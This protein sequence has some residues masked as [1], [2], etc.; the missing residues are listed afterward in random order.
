MRYH[1]LDDGVAGG[2][3]GGNESGPS[4]QDARVREGKVDKA[5]LPVEVAEKYMPLMERLSKMYAELQ[6]HREPLCYLR[7]ALSGLKR[8]YEK[9]GLE[10]PDFYN[11]AAECIKQSILEQIS[12]EKPKGRSELLS[13][14]MMEE[15]VTEE[16]PSLKMPL[17][18]REKRQIVSFVKKEIASPKSCLEEIERNVVKRFFLDPDRPSFEIIAEELDILPSHVEGIYESALTKLRK[19][20]G[21]VIELS[22]RATEARWLSFPAPN[23]KNTWKTILKETLR[24][25][26]FLDEQGKIKDYETFLNINSAFFASRKELGSVYRAYRKAIEKQYI[27]IPLSSKNYHFILYNLGFVRKG[28][29]FRYLARISDSELQYKERVRDELEKAGVLN[30]KGQIR[31]LDILLSINYK[32]FTTKR[33]KKSISSFYESY[34]KATRRGAITLPKGAAVHHFILKHLGF[35]SDR[36]WKKYLEHR[37]TKGPFPS[38]KQRVTWEFVLREALDEA[39]KLNAEGKIKDLE[40]LRGID[41]YFFDKRRGRDSPSAMY[42]AYQVAIVKGR[43]KIPADAL[44]QHLILWDLDFINDELWDSYLRREDDKKEEH[45]KLLTEVLR[46]TS[47]LNASGKIKDYDTLMSITSDFFYGRTGK[48]GIMT[49]YRAYRDEIKRGNIVLPQGVTIQHFLLRDLGFVS[50]KLWK[51]YLAPFYIPPKQRRVWRSNLRKALKAAD[52]LNQKGEIKDFN[53]LLSV[54]VMFF[55]VTRGND[56]P[57]SIYHAYQKAVKDNYIQIPEHTYVHHFV[58]R[59]LGF[60]SDELW[61]EYLAHPKP[62]PPKEERKEWHTLLRMALKRRDALNERG[63]IKN[64]KILLSKKINNTNLYSH[65]KRLIRIYTRYVAAH[66]QG[67]ITVPENVSIHHFLLKDLGF[68]SDDLWTQ[69]LEYQS[70]PKILTLQEKEEWQEKI[71]AKLKKTDK[72]NKDGKIKSLEALLSID[73]TIFRYRPHKYFLVYKRYAQALHKGRIQRPEVSKIPHFILYDLGF[74]SDEL[75]EE[76]LKYRSGPRILTSQQKAEWQAEMK[77]KLMSEE[78]PEKM[79]DKLLSQEKMDEESFIKGLDALLSISEAFF[80]TKEGKY[81]AVFERYQDAFNKGRIN[82]PKE[83]T[84]PHFILKDLGFISETLWQEYL[85]YQSGPQLCTPQHRQRWQVKI[86]DELKAKGKLNEEN[87]IKSLGALVRIKDTLLETKDKQCVNIFSRYNRAL[88]VGRIKKPKAATVLCLV[89]KELGFISEKLWQEYLAYNSGLKYFIPGEQKEWR[90]MLR[91]KLDSQGKLNKQG[92]VKDLEVLLGITEAIFRKGGEEFKI[93]YTEYVRVLR[94]A[95]IEWP[96][97]A[98]FHHFILKDLGFISDSLWEEYLDYRSGPMIFVPKEKGEWQERIKKKLKGQGKLNEQDQVI[99][100][101]TLLHISEDSLSKSIKIYIVRQRYA[102]ALRNGQITKPKNVALF[103]LILYDLGFISDNV[104]KQYVEY[105]TSTKQNLARGAGGKKLPDSMLYLLT[106]KEFWGI[107]GAVSE[108]FAL[109][110]YGIALHR[111][112]GFWLGALAMVGVIML[113]ALLHVLIAKCKFHPS[114]FQEGFPASFLRLL[115]HFI[116]PLILYAV[117]Y[118]NP[119]LIMLAIE[120]HLIIDIDRMSEKKKRRCPDQSGQCTPESGGGAGRR[121]N[122]RS[123]ARLHQHHDY[124]LDMPD[125]TGSNY[126]GWRLGMFSF[127]TCFKDGSGI[128][129]FQDSS[130]DDKSHGA[131]ARADNDDSAAP[132]TGRP[133]DKEKRVATDITACGLGIYE[134]DQVAQDVRNAVDAILRKAKDEDRLRDYQVNSDSMYLEGYIVDRIKKML[135]QGTTLLIVMPERSDCRTHLRQA[136]LWQDPNNRD[137]LLVGYYKNKVFYLSFFYLFLCHVTGHEFIYSLLDVLMKKDRAGRR[138]AEEGQRVAGIISELIKNKESAWV[139][140]V[141]RTGAQGPGPRGHLSNSGTL[142]SMGLLGILGVISVVLLILSHRVGAVAQAALFLP[143]VAGMGEKG[144]VRIA[145]TQPRIEELK[146]QLPNWDWENAAVVKWKELIRFSENEQKP[147]TVYQENYFN[148]SVEVR[149][150]LLELIRDLATNNIHNPA[151]F[152]E[153]FINIHKILL[154]GTS[155]DS[156]YVTNPDSDPE[157]NKRNAQN[158]AGKFWEQDGVYGRR[159]LEFIMKRLQVF[160]HPDSAQKSKEEATRFIAELYEIMIMARNI[161]VYGNHSWQTNLVNTLFRLYGL[162]GI[163][164]SALDIFIKSDDGLYINVQEELI[165][166]IRQAN[167]D[168]VSQNTSTVKPAPSAS[169]QLKEKGTSL[170]PNGKVSPEEAPDSGAG[171]G[172][173]GRNSRGRFPKGT[174][175]F[176]ALLV[177]L[178]AILSHRVGVGGLGLAQAA[179]FL[180]LVGMVTYV[181]NSTWGWT[182]RDSSTERILLILMKTTSVPLSFSF[183]ANLRLYRLNSGSEST[184]KITSASRGIFLVTSGC[185]II[186]RENSDDIS[187]FFLNSSFSVI[188]Y[189]PQEPLSIK[190]PVVL[191]VCFGEGE[192]VVV[193]LHEDRRFLGTPIRVDKVAMRKAMGCIVTD[194]RIPPTLNTNL[195]LHTET[196]YAALKMSMPVPPSTINR[197]ARDEFFGSDISHPVVLTGIITIPF[198]ESQ[199]ET[200]ATASQPHLKNRDS[201]QLS[202]R[203]GGAGG[204]ARPTSG[205]AMRAFRIDSLRGPAFPEYDRLRPPDYGALFG[206]GLGR[207]GRGLCDNPRPNNDEAAVIIKSKSG[208]QELFAIWLKGRMSRDELICQLRKQGFD[209]VYLENYKEFSL[210]GNSDIWYP[211]TLINMP[212]WRIYDITNNILA[213]GGGDGILVLRNTFEGTE[214]LAFDWGKGVTNERNEPLENISRLFCYEVSLAKGRFIKGVGIG[215]GGRALSLVSSDCAMIRAISI[216]K[217]YARVVERQPCIY[218]TREKMPTTQVDFTIPSNYREASGFIL[219]G[220]IPI[221]KNYYNG[222]FSRPCETDILGTVNTLQQNVPQFIR[223]DEFFRLPVAP[224]IDKLRIKDNITVH[225]CRLDGREKEPLINSQAKFIVADNS[226]LN[227]WFEIADGWFV[228]LN[229]VVEIEF[230]GKKVKADGYRGIKE[231]FTA[232]KLKSGDRV[233]ISYKIIEEYNGCKIYRG[234]LKEIPSADNQGVLVFESG[235]VIPCS[236][237]KKV[238]L[239]RGFVQDDRRGAGGG[240]GTQGPNGFR[241]GTFGSMALLGVLAGISVVSLTLL[242]RVGVG[243]LGLAQAAC[244]LPLVG[245]LSIRK[246]NMKLPQ[247]ETSSK[248]GLTIRELISG[249]RRS[250]LINTCGWLGS[251]CF[252]AY[253]MLSLLNSA[254]SSKRKTTCALAGILLANS[255]SGLA[256]RNRSNSQPIVLCRLQNS[257]SLT[258]LH[259]H[260][261]ALSDKIDSLGNATHFNYTSHRKPPLEEYTIFFKS[262]QD[263]LLTKGAVA[264]TTGAQGRGEVIHNVDAGL[265]GNLPVDKSR[266]PGPGEETSGGAGA[267]GA[268]AKGD[269]GLRGRRWRKATLELQFTLPKWGDIGA[270]VWQAVVR[271]CKRSEKSESLLHLRAAQA[272]VR[273]VRSIH[274]RKFKYVIMLGRS[275]SLTNLLFT[276]AWT[277]LYKDELMPAVYRF[278]DPKECMLLYWTMDL[279]DEERSAAVNKLLNSKLGINLSSVKQSKVVFLDDFVGGA[280]KF[281]SINR[282]FRTYGFQQ[283]YFAAYVASISYYIHAKF[284]IIAGCWNDELYWFFRKMARY[285]SRQYVKAGGSSTKDITHM[286]QGKTPFFNVIR[287]LSETLSDSCTS[288][289]SPVFLLGH[290]VGVPLAPEDLTEAGYDRQIDL[291]VGGIG[292]RQG[293]RFYH[294]GGG[295]EKSEPSLENYNSP[296][297]EITQVR[298][299]TGSKLTAGQWKILTGLLDPEQKLFSAREDENGPMEEVGKMLWVVLKSLLNYAE[300]IEQGWPNPFLNPRDYI[301]QM[302]RLLSF[303]WQYMDRD[304]RYQMLIEHGLMVCMEAHLKDLREESFPH[305]VSV[306]KEYANDIAKV[307]EAIFSGGFTIYKDLY[308]YRDY[309]HHLKGGLFYEEGDPDHLHAVREHSDYRELGIKPTLEAYKRGQER[310][311]YFLEREAE[312]YRR[313]HQGVLRG[314]ISPD[315]PF[316]PD[317]EIP[318]AH[319]L[320]DDPVVTRCYFTPFVDNFYSVQS[321][322]LERQAIKD[323]LEKNL[324]GSPHILE[325]GAGAG[326][327]GSIL[328][329]SRLKRNLQGIEWN[330]RALKEAHKNDWGQYVKRGSVY[331]LPYEHNSFDAVVSLESQDTFEDQERALSEIWRVLK[332]RGLFIHIGILPPEPNVC[333]RLLKERNITLLSVDCGIYGERYFYFENKAEEDHFLSLRR[334]LDEI[335]QRDAA[336]AGIEY[337]RWPHDPYGTVSKYL[338]S[339]ESY[340]W[341]KEAVALFNQMHEYKNVRMTALSSATFIEILKEISSRLFTF[342]RQDQIEDAGFCVLRKLETANSSPVTGALSE[343]AGS[344]DAQEAETFSKPNGTVPE[345]QSG[346]RTPESAGGAGGAKGLD[347]RHRGFLRLSLPDLRGVSAFLRRLAMTRVRIKY[348]LIL[349]SAFMMIDAFYLDRYFNL[350]QP[351]IFLIGNCMLIAGLVMFS[352]PITLFLYLS[353][354]LAVYLE[355]GATPESLYHLVPWLVGTGAACDWILAFTSSFLKR[356][357][358]RAFLMI[359]WEGLTASLGLA[360]RFIFVFLAVALP[361]FLL[362]PIFIFIVALFYNIAIAQLLLQ[363]QVSEKQRLAYI[364]VRKVLK[365]KKWEACIEFLERDEGAGPAVISI[366][367]DY[368]KIEAY[369]ERLLAKRKP[370]HQDI[371]LITFLLSGTLFDLILE[372]KQLDED[373]RNKFENLLKQLEEKSPELWQRIAPL[374]NDSSAFVDAWPWKNS[375][376]L[377]QVL[378]II[379]SLGTI[380]IIWLILHNTL[381]NIVSFPTTVVVS[382]LP[383]ILIGGIFPSACANASV[384]GNEAGFASAPMRNPASGM[385]GGVRFYQGGGETSSG[386]SY[387]DIVGRL[388]EDVSSKQAPVSFLII[389]GLAASGKSMLADSLKD[390]IKDDLIIH[391]DWFMKP[392]P[393]MAGM[394]LALLAFEIISIPLYKKGWINKFKDW[395][396]LNLFFDTEKIKDFI[397]WL[398]LSADCLKDCP[399]GSCQTEIEIS[400]QQDPVFF[401]RKRVA[402]KKIITLRKGTTVIIEGLFSNALFRALPAKRIHVSVDK[403]VHTQRFMDRLS[404]VSLISR[405]MARLRMYS[406]LNKWLINRYKWELKSGTYGYRLDL[407][408][409]RRP[410]LRVLGEG[411]TLSGT[412]GTVPKAQSGQRTPESAGGAGGGAQGRREVIHKVGAGL[413]GNLPVDKYDMSADEIEADIARRS[414]EKVPIFGEDGNAVVWEMEPWLF[415]VFARSRI[416]IMPEKRNGEIFWVRALWSAGRRFEEGF[417]PNKEDAGSRAGEGEG[418]K[419]RGYLSQLGWGNYLNITKRNFVKRY[420]E[421]LC[422]KKQINKLPQRDLKDLKNFAKCIPEMLKIK[423]RIGRTI[424]PQEAYIMI[425]DLLSRYRIQTIDYTGNWIMGL[426]VLADT[427][428][429]LDLQVEE[430]EGGARIALIPLDEAITKYHSGRYD[431]SEKTGFMKYPDWIIQLYS[432]RSQAA[433]FWDKDRILLQVDIKGNDVG[434]PYYVAEKK[435]GPKQSWAM[436][437]VIALIAKIDPAF[438]KLS[439]YLKTARPKEPEDISSLID[440]IGVSICSRGGRAGEDDGGISVEEIEAHITRIQKEKLKVTILKDDGSISRIME[441]KDFVRAARA[442]IGIMPKKVKDELQWFESPGSGGIFLPS[443]TPQRSQRAISRKEIKKVIKEINRVERKVVFGDDRSKEITNNLLSIGLIKGKTAFVVGPGIQDYLAICLCKLGIKISVIDTFIPTISLQRELHERFNLEKQIDA[444]SYYG[445]L[446]IKKF[447]YIFVLGVLQTI[448]TP[449]SEYLSTGLTS[450]AEATI[451]MRRKLKHEVRTFI[452]P[453]IQCLNLH[454]GYLLVNSKTPFSAEHCRHD[455][456]VQLRNS[457]LYFLDEVLKALGAKINISFTVQDQIDIDNLVMNPGFFEKRKGVVYK[458]KKLQGR[459][460]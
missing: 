445:A 111:L 227:A 325:V 116:K 31:D 306:R 373:K 456:Y 139:G 450:L 135:P 406:P 121:R 206:R 25:T 310:E 178:G 253:S 65:S 278:A 97:V 289:G 90:Q 303:F 252:L 58:L 292:L 113:W 331:S 233:Q 5:Y 425:S 158:A 15:E 431:V 69:Y 208:L 389:D 161:F 120:V 284:S 391:S 223:D 297:V 82:R 272:V 356:R 430:F 344:R 403:K 207:A 362:T 202:N 437:T 166:M 44:I 347:L 75:W 181:A 17:A 89:L 300:R 21:K 55:H 427:V 200:T 288:E 258:L 453:V 364:F 4:E 103:Y 238:D 229:S 232:G 67:R 447:D 129:A 93:I 137:R 329:A 417:G 377:Y 257:L 169:P 279:S 51:K 428:F 153:R 254:L 442:R 327:L 324:P 145:L 386:K 405:L 332:K 26:G 304:G 187:R 265:N 14:L 390:R 282:H 79:R 190:F 295:A 387:I 219:H 66:R 159:F 160:V 419:K 24:F 27:Q 243:G 367:E 197:Q 94:R 379:F 168:L 378:W 217:G 249:S 330:D 351:P 290:D 167:P 151:V 418:R 119:V 270:R 322:K 127:G 286:F 337:K 281:S 320:Y 19:V 460:R 415:D 305:P 108:A 99:D 104:W 259:L 432:L 454:G 440:E 164:H 400:E 92:Q 128:K 438:T 363:H 91:V 185:V 133:E 239:H 340:R 248:W 273:V 39:G 34:Q 357:A 410:A 420:E 23:Q 74:I 226:L 37:R 212:R 2:A 296:V 371:E 109:V 268:G 193:V 152:I 287:I 106:G 143:L 122:S 20:I 374:A 326:S 393:T 41:S 33:G 188:F 274:D 179:C 70:G 359:K 10:H 375:L 196:N 267:S 138:Y 360:S 285:V 352:L 222:S 388:A 177:I 49:I 210:K 147:R 131:E 71:K 54:D 235:L 43:K 275:S 218:K 76:Y 399:T 61:K 228:D 72:L 251:R 144:N 201:D 321:G 348:L 291:T 376:P 1:H 452:K 408:D 353:V 416:G 241:P 224:E 171:R 338:H 194:H 40:T 63:K 355:D 404:R 242:H 441:S 195:Q 314:T 105:K 126:I 205:P 176:I 346:Q 260:P 236:C 225:F 32:F 397:D 345:V 53:T 458:S 333:R 36:L 312:I 77:N 319:V 429:I 366:K 439:R 293:R 446:K 148:N 298:A 237:V 301:D 117:A 412:I 73:E 11:L 102:R 30:S 457:E 230:K 88:Q 211:Y 45:K 385:G 444:V 213:Y 334:Q 13:Q 189:L 140:G 354:S 311:I 369:L 424:K 448:V 81:L 262:R 142:G 269:S 95:K 78:W 175:G 459:G 413:N 401:W 180:P 191:Q 271:R 149:T 125:G 335:N 280:V 114:I 398:K 186:Y 381:S 449:I 336:R 317:K 341:S 57:C 3:R 443:G 266:D 395:A 184:R 6:E 392:M 62:F 309:V 209:G 100:L 231:I 220:F 12:Q 60:I 380:F 451:V 96:R 141:G 343:E 87:K 50:D 199:A 115:W 246:A 123:R 85:K 118:D 402:Q 361:T 174:L 198:R 68:I 215:G 409:F 407:N 86:R 372:S 203:G 255:D 436:R 98:V 47:K 365:R 130:P 339:D 18:L 35:V 112:L 315:A 146:R 28:I 134:E 396:V 221:D 349:T 358:D 245:G 52:K 38:Y 240:R 342:I 250:I 107:F 42:K 370:G 56:S 308:A 434:K 264:G 84:L 302:V 328:Q 154:L 313:R 299:Q 382:G 263:I 157:V 182:R 234:T 435:R 101:E 162:Q 46:E 83:S 48:K 173:Q 433:E 350:V 411:E 165:G 163:A 183:L 455:P 256:K 294:G 7:A 22:R 59:D 414:G 244:F 80:K 277:R 422:A 316:D 8:A 423:R 110:V 384:A 368:P 216:N 283:I 156:I 261:R 307:I 64:L 192:S 9:Y 383:P 394:I 214:F 204:A 150:A 172:A 276:E 421:V 426:V 136:I 318:A 124:D 323:Y 132:A 170:Q 29:W 16:E 155:G 247:I